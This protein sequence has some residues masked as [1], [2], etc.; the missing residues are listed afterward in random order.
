MNKSELYGQ[1][2][3]EAVGIANA[4]PRM[5]SFLKGHIFRKGIDPDILSLEYNRRMIENVPPK[6]A[7]NNLNN[8]FSLL[9]QIASDALHESIYNNAHLL[10]LHM[11]QNAQEGNGFSL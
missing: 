1:I 4:D 6:I 11:A 10:V 9:D 5:P 3:E 2:E 8:I 7:G